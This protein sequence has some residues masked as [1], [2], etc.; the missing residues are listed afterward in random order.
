MRL[1]WMRLVAALAVVL[2]A[3]PAFAAET[4]V[5]TWGAPPDQAGPPLAG[6]SVR[7]V[8]RVSLGGSR[9]RL[10]LSNLYGSAPV[11]IGPVRLARPDGGAGGSGVRAGTSQAVTFGGRPVVTIPAGAAVLSDPADFP[12][13]ALEE[14]AVS[15]YVSGGAGETTV[16]GV[17]MQTA[18][19]AEGDATAAARFPKGGV[20]YGR[21]FV[22]DVDVAA[23]AA[24][25]SIVVIGD[26]ITDGVGSADNMNY[27]WTD[28]LAE[29]LQADANL[30]RIAVV[31]AGIAGNRILNDAAAPFVGPSMLSRFDRDALDKPGVRW[32]I[33]LAGVN[34][35]SAAG[36]LPDP[37]QKV[38]AEQITA[39]MKTLVDRAHA[40]GLKVYGATLLPRDGGR[41]GWEGHQPM[42]EAVNAWI[43]T[44]GAF[45]A[46]ID[47]E[48]VVQDPTQPGRLRPAFDSGDHTH[49]NDAGYAAMAAAVD[50]GL[51]ADR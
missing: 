46:V 40:R 24:A 7:Q 26:S 29:R 16:H 44:S 34:D 45:D 17:G 4:W 12:V 47:F 11:T 27:R 3:A 10:R 6:R 31:N 14:M 2:G 18:F 39:G 22:T 20:D 15:L 33:L 51:F 43:R 37:K 9:V 42:R 35:I 48:R 28:A 21:L 13:A 49:P 8:M 50:L 5:S 23:A 1:G 41:F 36:T 19:T 38:T 32:I 25:R 30:R